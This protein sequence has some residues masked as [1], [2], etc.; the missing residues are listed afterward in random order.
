METLIL[1]RRKPERLMEGSCQEDQWT[2]PFVILEII[3]RV[4]IIIL[5]QDFFLRYITICRC[6]VDF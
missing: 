4:W 6:S 2:I 3:L 1:A 5:S